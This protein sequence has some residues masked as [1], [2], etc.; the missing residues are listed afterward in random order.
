MSDTVRHR[1]VCRFGL[2]VRMLRDDQHAGMPQSVPQAVKRLYGGDSQGSNG[3]A[4]VV[5]S[6]TGKCARRCRAAGQAGAPPPFRSAG[7]LTKS[8]RR[9]ILPQQTTTNGSR[10][11]RHGR[12]HRHR[13]AD[14]PGP[15]LRATRPPGPRNWLLTKM[16]KKRDSESQRQL[17]G[18][19]HTPGLSREVS[20]FSRPC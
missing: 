5:G 6:G 2:G 18:V 20:L 16:S 8:N 19:S 13:S 9:L 7:P 1:H 11:R 14:G 15:R 17:H 3:V 10:R 12:R 4:Q